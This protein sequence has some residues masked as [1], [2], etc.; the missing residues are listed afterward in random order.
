MR[1]LNNIL[2]NTTNQLGIQILMYNR[3][4]T[5]SLANVHDADVLKRVN[6]FVESIASKEYI[7]P[8]NLQ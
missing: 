6:A 8:L 1:T 3:L 5:L 4:K 2:K 7:N